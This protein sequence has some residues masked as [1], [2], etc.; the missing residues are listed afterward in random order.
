M[1]NGSSAFDLR[2]AG[3][4]IPPLSEVWGVH[5]VLPG[6]STVVECN[7]SAA[8]IENAPLDKCACACRLAWKFCRLECCRGHA[9]QD[10]FGENC[11]CESMP[12]W[13]GRIALQIAE[14][15]RDTRRGS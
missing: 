13:N 2:A 9:D 11:G 8:F 1:E 10:Q 12:A 4:G 14:P 6:T 15:R 3:L 5:T 7:K